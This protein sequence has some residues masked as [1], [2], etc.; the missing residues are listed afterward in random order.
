MAL[1]RCA[2]CLEPFAPDAPRFAVIKY[3]PEPQG[4]APVWDSP[5][6]GRWWSRNWQDFVCAD[7]AG[8]Y[9]DHAI[10]VTADEA[11]A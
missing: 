6:D 7:C 8:W 4:E 10:E 11:E 5:L 9:S 3:E 1:P 2:D